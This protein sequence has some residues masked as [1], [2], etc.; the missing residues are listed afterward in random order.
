VQQILVLRGG[1]RLKLSVE[2]QRGRQGKCSRP[3]LLEQV[4][5]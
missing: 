4:A 1:D 3:V 5:K 2:V